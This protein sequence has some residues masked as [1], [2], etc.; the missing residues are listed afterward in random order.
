VRDTLDGRVL[1]GGEDEDIADAAERDALIP[2]KLRTLQRKLGDLLPQ[3]DTRPELVWSGSFGETTTGLPLIGKVRHR[4][5]CWAVLGFGGNGTL[6]ARI[7]ADII[8]TALAGGEDVDAD[9]FAL[10][11]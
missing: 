9:L 7:A 10:P 2:A 6:F 3:I 11:G 1:C 4:K 8:S 5:G